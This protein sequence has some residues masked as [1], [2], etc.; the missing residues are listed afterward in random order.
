MK[1][2]C[3][4]LCAVDGRANICRGCGRSLKEI[5]DWSMMSGAERDKVLR[6]L[7]ARI[8]RLG[9]RASAPEEALAKIWDALEA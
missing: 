6:D 3:L 9:D 2:P 4:S 8:A 1:S 7:P 5:A